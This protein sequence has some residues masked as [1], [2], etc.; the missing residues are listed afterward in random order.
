MLIIGRGELELL[1]TGRTGETAISLIDY[2]NRS[3]LNTEAHSLTDK[4][5]TQSDLEIQNYVKY[6]LEM[7]F[8]LSRVKVAFLF[9]RDSFPTFK[10]GSS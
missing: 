2:S 4:Q 1:M 9:L 3:C 8:M 7:F 5:Y 6:K 10:I